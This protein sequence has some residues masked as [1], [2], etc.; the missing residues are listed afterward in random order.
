MAR[1]VARW[2]LADVRGPVVVVDAPAPALQSTSVLVRTSATLIS[3]GTERAATQLAQAS[4]AQKAHCSMVAAFIVAR[5]QKALP[6]APRAAKAKKRCALEARC[7]SHTNRYTKPRVRQ[8]APVA[9]QV[10]VS[11]LMKF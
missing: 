10:I 4:L 6:P 5:S 11:G 3:A 7:W 2:E 9:V 1:H 8:M